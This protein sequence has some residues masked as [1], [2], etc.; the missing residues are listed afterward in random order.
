MT[1]IVIRSITPADHE[2]WV[3]L[4][5]GYISFCRRAFD[6][7]SVE[8]LWQWLMAEKI[9]CLVAIANKQMVGLAHAKEQLSPLNGKVVGYLDDLFVLEH[10]RGKGVADR[11]M[12]HLKQLGQ[13]R[14]WLFIR[15]ITR[16]NNY[17][18]KAFYDKIAKKTM[19][20]TYQLSL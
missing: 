9:F 5:S 14:H 8:T 11:L 4:Y 15:W 17:R 1:D 2:E 10:Y 12:E 16:E 6:T 3:K 7:D 20:H 13:A 19:W 18:A